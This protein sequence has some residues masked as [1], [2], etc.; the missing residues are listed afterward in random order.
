MAKSD[1]DHLSGQIWYLTR[2]CHRWQFLLTLLATVTLGSIG[3]LRREEM[4]WLRALDYG[5]TSNQVHLRVHDRQEPDL[6]R[7][8]P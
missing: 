6:E 5:F 7:K 8:T 1:L 4:I 2:R 3:C